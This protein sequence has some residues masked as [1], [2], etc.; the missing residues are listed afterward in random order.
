MKLLKLEQTY[1]DELFKLPKNKRF[2]ILSI[3][4]SPL[5]FKHSSETID[6]L[7]K[8]NY[9]INNPSYNKTNSGN[10]G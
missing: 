5:G 2:N 10:K 4:G 8:I 6:Y 1:L 9:G 7:S 3:A